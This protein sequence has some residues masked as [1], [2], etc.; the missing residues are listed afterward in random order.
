[1]EAKANFAATSTS[2]NNPWILETGASH[3]ITDDSRNIHHPQDYS[4][5]EEIILGI[6]EDILLSVA[7]KSTAK[8]AWDA[9]KTLCL[10]ADR[11]K[12]ARA[13]T[14]KAEFEG[15]NMKDSEK[16]DDFCMKL[17]GLVTN[18]RALGETIE[19]SYVV[20][21]LLR[22]VP[23]KFL[24]IASTI[25]Q[26]G[27]VEEM[28]VEEAVGSLKAHEE[29][30]CGHV[31]NTGEQLLLTEQE[32]SKMENKDGQLLLT[33]EEWMKR[34]N[35]GGTE[36]QNS[37]YRGRENTRGGRDRRTIRCFNCSNFGHYAA[38]CRNPRREKEQSAEANLVQT[39][40]DEPALLLVEKCGE[41]K[42]NVV[43]MN[44]EIKPRLNAQK[45]TGDES[46]VWYLDNGASN[47]MTGQRSKFSSL[48]E[49]IQG[50]VKFGDGSLVEIKG[51]GSIVL[52]YKNGEER[53]LSEVYYIPKLCNN[54]ISLGQLS[55]EGNQVTLSEVTRLW[56][57][58]LG[59]VNYQAMKLMNVNEMAHG[60]PSFVQPKEACSG[61]LM[62]KQAR[63]PFPRQSDFKA[64]KKLELIHG[65]LCGPIS[66][67]T[68]AGNR[69]FL[70][71]VDDYSRKM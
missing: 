30:L 68:T 65:D 6:P 14:L 26:F 15:L 57:A 49:K 46:N 63:K 7:D 59:H 62:T 20:K 23:S 71:L 3:H 53:T 38:E 60:L 28:S 10:G 27:N 21:K 66:P 70:L 52:Q 19:E 51:R 8:E 4:G 39:Q 2:F 31:E 35:K 43:L 37:R 5:Q 32:L 12:K 58:R 13:Q 18:I 24:Q 55:E 54:I 45:T 42:S 22:A 47:H 11:V 34:S 17:N 40:D 36:P 64:A 41:E 44:E 69:Y 33:R 67:P 61:C 16:L 29:R 48:D 56:H 25:E 1:M 9:I 50:Q